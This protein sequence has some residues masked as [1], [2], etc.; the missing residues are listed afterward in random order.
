MIRYIFSTVGFLAGLWRIFTSHDSPSAGINLGS[1]PYTVKVSSLEYADDAGLL[2]A[3]VTDASARMSAISRGS[4]EEAAMIISVPKTKAMHVHKTVEVTDTTEGEITALHLKHKCPDCDR[5]FPTQHGMRVHRGRWCDG[6]QTVRSRK[7]SLADKAVQLS[8]RKAAENERE[9]VY[10]EGDEI[11]NVHSFVYLGSKLQC[12]G[13]DLADVKHRMGI[14]QAEFSALSRF[15]QDRRMP[16]SVR[17]R[18]YKSAVCSTL[19]HACEA[20]TLTADVRRKINGFNSRC[21]HVLTG[22]SYRDTATRPAY[23]LVL[24]IRRRRL[25][26]LGLVLR[27]HEDR[28]VRRSLLAYVHGGNG[29]PDGSLLDDCPVKYMDTLTAMAHDRRGWQRLVSKLS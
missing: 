10:I 9:H 24:A 11:E 25:K 8:K 12:D 15:W 7:G 22:D 27:M 23:D 18:I 19:T 1:A 13:E 17:L 28:L 16:M 2:D 4:R 5:P 20:W 26:F 3:N 14:A 21:L 29:A 6:G